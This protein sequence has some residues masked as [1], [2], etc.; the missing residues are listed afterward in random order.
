M[1]CFEL[2]LLD[3]WDDVIEKKFNLILKKTEITVLFLIL[4]KSIHVPL[5]ISFELIMS[6]SER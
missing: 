5:S 1:F 6:T 3:R 2:L 4:F